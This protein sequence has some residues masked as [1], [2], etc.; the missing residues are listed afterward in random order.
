VVGAA[1]DGVLSPRTAVEL[2]N[3]GGLGCLNLEGLWTR[4]EDPD[5]LFEEIADLAPEKATRRMQEIYAEPIKE[6]LI[7]Q[8]IRE[9]KA[10]GVVSCASLTP[11]RVERYARHVLDA[12]LDI[13][14]I[15]GTVVS[16]EHVSRTTE[17]LN[18]KRFIRDFEIPVIVGGC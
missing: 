17:P 18:L 10:A 16:A 12:E 4:Y 15:Q 11:Q 1:M 14:V 5:A 8:R 9:V 6:E 13:L 2:A 7:G 3:L